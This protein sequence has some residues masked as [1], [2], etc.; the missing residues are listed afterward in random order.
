MSRFTR[1]LQ[2]TIWLQ[3][4]V[5][6]LFHEGE[7]LVHS[8][9]ATSSAANAAE[10]A[11][12]EFLTRGGGRDIVLSQL[13]MLPGMARLDS[14]LQADV[15][16]ML[17]HYFCANVAFGPYAAEVLGLRQVYAFTPG[18][19]LNREILAGLFEQTLHVLQRE[20]MDALVRH[21]LMWCVG[22]VLYLLN[23]ASFLEDLDSR[24][25]TVAVLDLDAYDLQWPQG[26]P[27]LKV[28]FAVDDADSADSIFSGWVKCALRES[29]T[30]GGAALSQDIVPV[31]VE[32]QRRGGHMRS[33]NQ[34]NRTEFYMALKCYESTCTF[35]DQTAAHDSEDAARDDAARMGWFKP[36]T[37][38]WSRARC[39]KCKCSWR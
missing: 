34:G 26:C 9:R 7:G 4:Q 5:G 19:A 16:G 14:E 39:P 23:S 1:W 8:C 25:Y 30:S 27:I 24:A 6:N 13:L 22:C 29:N 38:G 35:S 36:S 12:D 2:D 28:V 15:C 18:L 33:F 11:G 10:N 21:M 3:F 37:K 32:V 31:E 20:G 17:V